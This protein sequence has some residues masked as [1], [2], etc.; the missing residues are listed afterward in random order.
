MLYILRMSCSRPFKHPTLVDRFGEPIKIPCGSCYSCREDLQRM[1]VDRMFVAWHSHDVSAFVT[2]T[3]DDAHLRF[4]EGFDRPTLSKQDVHRYLDNIKHRLK[5][6]DF[7]YFLAGE[8]GDKFGRPHYHCI[9]FGL[10]Y[11]I[12]KKF[13]EQS[14][15]L[16]SVKV[17][18]VNA[19]CFQYVAKYICQP[20]AKEYRDSNFYDLGLEPPFRKMS[21]GLGLSV[22]REHQEELDRQ[23]YFIFHGKKI[24]L[25]RYYFNKLI[26]RT[27]MIH[28]AQ[29]KEH[30]RIEK[31]DSEA[32]KFFG[33]TLQEYRIE[34]RER[35]ERFLRQ[36]NLNKK[37]SLK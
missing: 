36:K 11:Q 17:L 22:Y 32:A 2:F 23:G 9:F 10:D 30:F 13:F 24:T 3:Y 8:Y 4:N 12:H 28:V 6:I 14:W 26:L 7:E 37:S 19:S 18:P 27:P 31:R 20:Y 33:M 1:A 29:D 15:K 16:G 35:R 21:R 25:N 34:M 5:K